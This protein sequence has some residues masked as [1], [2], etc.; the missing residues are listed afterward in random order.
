[1]PAKLAMARSLSK[2]DS[3]PQFVMLPIEL[4]TL[5]WKHFCPDLS[6]NTGNIIY[7]ALVRM[8]PLHHVV[9]ETK[10]VAENTRALRAVLATHRESRKL[11]LTF[12]PDTYTFRDGRGEIRINSE[13][14]RIIVK[15][16]TMESVR[17]TRN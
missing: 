1:M 17:G 3:F 6:N 5:I 15:A 16:R 2:K 13:R 11:G 4:R 10:G 12:F 9:I 8:S 7:M 14:D